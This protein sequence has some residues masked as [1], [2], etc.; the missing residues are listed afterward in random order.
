MEQEDLGA[1]SDILQIPGSEVPLLTDNQCFII[2]YYCLHSKIHPC[3]H[4]RFAY[5]FHLYL[6]D[7]CLMLCLAALHKS[8]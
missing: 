5:T 4:V 8:V 1:A 3:Q 2:I 6:S 7:L